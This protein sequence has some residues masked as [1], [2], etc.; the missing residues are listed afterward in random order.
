MTVELA[1]DAACDD[2]CRNIGLGMQWA[3]LSFLAW[4]N[5]LRVRSL[6]LS[7]GKAALVMVT[8]CVPGRAATAVWCAAAINDRYC[9]ARHSQTGLTT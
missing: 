2:G 9:R 3:T 4:G 7:T 8:C 5:S 1:P 6:G